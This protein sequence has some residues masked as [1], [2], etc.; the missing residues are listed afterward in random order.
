MAT[1]N[2]SLPDPMRDWVQSRIDSGQYGNNSDYIRDLIRRDQERLGK[3][4]AMQAAIDEGLASGIAREF[5]KEAFKQ[6]MK[7]HQ[8][9]QVPAATQR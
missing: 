1:M 2:I 4:K 5:D 7:E 6:R 8:N 3:I 9:E